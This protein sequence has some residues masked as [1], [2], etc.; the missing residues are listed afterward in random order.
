MSRQRNTQ[1]THRIMNQVPLFGQGFDEHASPPDHEPKLVRKLA[2]ISLH[3]SIFCDPN[4]HTPYPPHVSHMLSF[5]VSHDPSPSPS[6]AHRHN[7][8][9]TLLDHLHLQ[10]R[11]HD[12]HHHHHEQHPAPA[13]AVAAREM[14]AVARAGGGGG[15]GGSWVALRALL[16]ALGTTLSQ[17]ENAPVLLNALTL[18]HTTS[19]PGELVQILVVHYKGQVKNV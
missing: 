10:S 19:S 13:P 17:I 4:S 9:T 14:A 5:D 7:I 8:G 2:Q 16:R 6:L 15:G 3:R 1:T 18:S 11:G 12:H